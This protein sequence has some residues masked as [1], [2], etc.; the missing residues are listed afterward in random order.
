MVHS[1]MPDHW[2]PLA[3]VARSNRWSLLRTAKV[4]LLAALG[5]TVASVLLG[6]VIAAVGL[7]FRSA[8]IAQ[9]GHVVGGVLIV[10]GLGFL[11]YAIVQAARGHGGHTH[12]HPHPHAHVRSVHEDYGAAP[13]VHIHTRHAHP[14]HNRADDHAHGQDQGQ[15]DHP[16]DGHS[17]AQDEPAGPEHEQDHTHD[18]HHG[19]THPHSLSRRHMHDRAHHHTHAEGPSQ[20]AAGRRT[21]V[22]SQVIVPFGI[23]ASPDLTVLP[24]FLAASAL[25]VWP[26][27]LVLI[28]FAV[29]TLATFVVLTVAATLG[30]YQVEWPWLE[31]NG[32]LVSA[33]LLL[34]IGVLA[35][36]RF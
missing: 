11:A 6:L 7:A 22:I 9:E 4:S 34:A 17:H 12:S 14:A 27:V 5:H 10:T 3:I 2:V 33:L 19:H 21:N 18:H 15:A 31:A 36:L 23:A 1:V 13:H 20:G 26:A 30:G 25:G 32:H 16:D 24:V 8:I 29:A 28:V 35:Y